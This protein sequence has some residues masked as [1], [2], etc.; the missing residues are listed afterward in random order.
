MGIEVKDLLSIHDL[1]SNEINDILDL[2][3]T[4]KTQLKN[5]EQHHLLKGKTLGMIFQKASTRTRV[6]FEVGMWQLGGAA[7]FLNANDMQIGRGEPVK[8]TA[9]VLSRYVDGIMIR[10]FSH[11]EVIELAQFATIP[12]INALTDLM[13]PCQALTD[14]FT[15]LEHK[16]RLQGLKMVYIGDGNNMVN[17]LLQACAKVG[18]DISIA[19]PKGYEPDAA[20]V[21]EALTAAAVTGSKIVLCEDP[22]EAA[23]DADVL[24]TDVWA[25]MGKEIEQEDR[26]EV[27]VNYQ[28]NQSVMDA[29]KKDAIV[30]HC[31]PA[32]R[33]E[34]ITEEVLESKQSVVFDQAENRLHVQKAIMVLLMGK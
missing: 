12:V 34:E 13:H 29:A 30:L 33:G 18:M 20:V 11:D 31:L 19:T 2:A 14:I 10:T 4:L 15:V 6:S 16:G 1:S 24:Y 3:K 25:S 26:R 9:R 8:D 27:F 32:H 5:G 22:L 21:A 17:S 28:I 7:L 23:K